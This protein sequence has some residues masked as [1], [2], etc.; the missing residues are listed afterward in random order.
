MRLVLPLLVTSALTTG[1][2]GCGVEPSQT[3]LDY[4]ACQRAYEDAHPDAVV[5]DTSLYEA[6]GAC[7]NNKSTAESCTNACA[8]ALDVLDTSFDDFNCGS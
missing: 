3:C 4:V 1:A 5:A 8:E 7:W 2:L 6:E